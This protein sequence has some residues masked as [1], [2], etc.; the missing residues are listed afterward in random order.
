MNK[1][2]QS[3]L[4]F[5]LLVANLKTIIRTG[6]ID[7]EISAPRLESVAEHIYG[8]QMLAIA[9]VSEYKLD[10]DLRK[11][12]FMLAVHELGETIVG[13][14][15]PFS[16]ITKDEK[17]RIELEVVEKIL[18]NLAIGNEIK[19]I[20]IEFEENKTPEAKFCKQVD[21]LEADIQAKIYD[22]EGFTDFATART[23]KLEKERQ[24]HISV[25]CKNFGDAFAN[26]DINHGMF[27]DEVF[28]EFIKFV[29]DNKL[30][31]GK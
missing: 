6:W 16:N 13:D 8:T 28:M 30:E 29:R 19:D 25:G 22:Q 18:A 21:K 20:Y 9:M 23:G 31:V 14:F 26:Y 7:W 2:I 17:R 24:Y 5:Y 11:I 3:V 15:S 1:R 4:D 27:P 12:V 10:L